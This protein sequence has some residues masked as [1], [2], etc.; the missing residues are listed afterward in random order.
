MHARDTVQNNTKDM[1]RAKIFKNN[2]P[3]HHSNCD[4]NVISFNTNN[5]KQTNKQTKKQKKI[6]T[7][8]E[9]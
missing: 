7:E 4:N 9:H 6:H 2:V 1:P 5:V 3:D 8:N